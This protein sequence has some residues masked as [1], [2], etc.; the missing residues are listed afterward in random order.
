MSLS[1]GSRGRLVTGSGSPGRF[2]LPG[3]SGSLY[4]DEVSLLIG[5]RGRLVTGSLGLRVDLVSLGGVAHS[6]STRSLC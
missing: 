1:I 2:G 6:T 4:V 5:S 3:W